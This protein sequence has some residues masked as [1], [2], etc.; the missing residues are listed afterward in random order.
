MNKGLIKALNEHK[1]KVAGPHFLFSAENP[2]TKP[3]L[4]M[5]HEQVLNHL[6][7]AGYDAHGVNGH[8]GAPERSIIVYG[9]NHEQ[10]GHLHKLAA[11]LG[12]HSSLHSDGSNHELLIHHG[13]E[14][15]N[16]IRGQGTQWHATKPSDNYTSL[17]GGVHHFSHQLGKSEGDIWSKRIRGGSV[18]AKA[19][20]V[21]DLLWKS[22]DEETYKKY[23]QNGMALMY[24]V[25]I[26]GRTHR[27][28]IG[29][30]YHSTIKLFDPKKDSAD[31]AHE[32]ASQTP[33]RPPDPKHVM[34][35]PITLKGREG[36]TIHAIALS[37]PHEHEA[38][39]NNAKFSHM[40]FVQ[41][42]EFKP[43]ISVDKKTW[44]HI[45]N[46]GFKT[47]HDAGI[48]F[49][50]A[51]LRQ[52]DNLLARYPHK[53]RSATTADIQAVREKAQGIKARNKVKLGK[54]EVLEK[55]LMR[56]LGATAATAATIAGCALKPMPT[57][58]SP[59]AGSHQIE[60]TNLANRYDH[61]RMLDAIAQVESSGGK[62]TEHRPTSQGTAYG[63]Y[64]LM[65]NTIRDTI[66]LD[67]ALS[68]K[69]KDALNLDNDQLADYLNSNPG[70][71]QQI[72]NSH[73]SRLEH[74]F[75]NNRDAIA[76]GWNQGIVG[77]NRALKHKKDFSHHPYVA[78]VRDAYR[79]DKI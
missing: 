29:I 14:A 32:I 51:E 13:P 47:A 65:P 37:G 63:K 46:H 48:T 39:A 45:K 41:N 44:E 58:H 21:F 17:P 75:G 28:D 9:I 27:P 2:F 72:A 24:P 42:Y 56:Q 35:E 68:Q 55:G 20:P 19:E 50:A 43:H 8:Y 3:E 18:L 73:L 23:A 54:S 16:S 26:Q 71:E 11:R 31:Q 69:H 1:E 59:N 49:H 57:E 60:Q 30:Q 7:S 38:K 6:Q 62:N 4:K 22:S 67:Q 61:N 36:N 10:A 70:L 25:R 52:G 78:K 66:H 79:K 74:H 76:F 40:G 34:L 53:N 15:G 33:L 5:S 77:T 12:Q 64:A